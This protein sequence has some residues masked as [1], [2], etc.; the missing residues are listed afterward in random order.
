MKQSKSE[1]RSHKSRILNGKRYAHAISLLECLLSIIVIASIAM[2]AVRYYIVTTR[3]MHVSQ[4]ISQIKRITDASY[5]WLQMQKQANFSSQG[6]GY[7]ITIQQL[8][9]DQLLTAKR[10]TVTPWGGT[11]NVAP[12]GDNPSF[13]KITLNNVPQ[14]ACRNIT[15]QL[16]YINKAQSANACGNKNNN[17]FVGEF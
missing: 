11:I 1:Y 14:S 10:D 4:A 3:S 16:K 6:G 9:N 15:Q 17:I 2:M 8:I 5:E 12:A 13:V 7:A